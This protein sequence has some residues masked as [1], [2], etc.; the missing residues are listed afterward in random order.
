MKHT[1]EQFLILFNT[2]QQAAITTIR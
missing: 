1:K 2:T